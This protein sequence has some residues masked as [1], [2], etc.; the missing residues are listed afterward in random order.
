MAIPSNTLNPLLFAPGAVP[1]GLGP[2]KVKDRRAPHRSGRT[3][4]ARA[5]RAARRLRGLRPRPRP[6]RPRV[7][8][9]ASCWNPDCRDAEDYPRIFTT[10]RPRF[11]CH[12]ESDG[13][14]IN[15]D[16]PAYC[17]T[18]CRMHAANLRDGA[19]LD[20]F[21]A[22][23]CEAPNCDNELPPRRRRRG[24]A[25]RYR[26]GRPARFCGDRCR[27]AAYRLAHPMP[28]V[29][30]PPTTC[31]RCGAAIPRVERAGRPR[32]TCDDCRAK[33]AAPKA[34]VSP[35]TLAAVVHDGAPVEA[36]PDEAALA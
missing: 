17:S 13:W 23:V 6:R 7:S 36:D 25:M 22:G 29:P 24:R 10:K 3:V 9:L 8:A 11:Q 19:P 21:D 33:A 16:V 20:A 14:V 2:P 15:P 4:E 34:K 12:E 5:R 35:K 28:F 30:L 18:R 26:A 31:R 27:K 32:T 1:S